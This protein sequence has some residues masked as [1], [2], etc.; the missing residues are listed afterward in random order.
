MS[1]FFYKKNDGFPPLEIKNKSS[2]IKQSVIEIDGSASSQYISALIIGLAT[3]KKRTKIK[4]KGK[5]ISFP[6]VLMTLKLLKTFNVN[7]KINE[8]YN[9]I[10]IQSSKLKSPEEF[11]SNLIYRRLV[12]LLL[13]LFLAVVQL[14]YIR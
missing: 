7:F 10:L 11:L 4:I 12:T 6:Y 3:L 9:E 5:K 8:N 2:E 14:K 1:N 13:W